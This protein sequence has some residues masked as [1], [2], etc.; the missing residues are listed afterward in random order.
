MQT[1]P[2]FAIAIY[3]NHADAEEAVKTL[4]RAGFDMK[5][6]SIIGKDY[7][8]EEHVIGFLN[9]GD[10]ARIFGKY[11][12]MWGG[13][14]GLLFGST[15]M[16]VP[17]V[18]HLVVLGPLAATLVLGLE[19]AVAIGGASALVGALTAIGMPKDSVLRY[20]RGPRKTFAPGSNG[21]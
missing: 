17:L 18:G 21:G 10:R 6:V 12:A 3:D 7:Q 5:I 19:G 2:A 14:M 4:Q 1:T 20:E 9:A 11:G 13:L 8:T 16:F 15:M